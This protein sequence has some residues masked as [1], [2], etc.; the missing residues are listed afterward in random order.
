MGFV[1]DFVELPFA[2][3]YGI[4]LLAALV[5]TISFVGITIADFT[6]IPIFNV[7]GGALTQILGFAVYTDYRVFVILLF[8]IGIVLFIN[9]FES[10]N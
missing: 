5:T 8:V 1:D 6:L 9:H 10:S 4:L 3:K 2:F 7:F